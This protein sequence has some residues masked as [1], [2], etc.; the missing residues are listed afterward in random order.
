[1]MKSSA[2]RLVSGRFGIWLTSMRRRDGGRLRLQD[3]ARLAL[4]D[5][6]FGQLADLERHFDGRRRARR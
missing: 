5:H 2:L 3:G 4:H 1:M 6:R